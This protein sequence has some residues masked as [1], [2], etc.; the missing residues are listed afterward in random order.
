MSVGWRKVTSALAEA[1]DEEE[2]IED[3]VQNMAMLVKSRPSASIF[4]AGGASDSRKMRQL[5]KTRRM[6]VTIIL[7]EGRSKSPA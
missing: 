2:D 4:E 6:V 5:G 3:L 7:A 1:G